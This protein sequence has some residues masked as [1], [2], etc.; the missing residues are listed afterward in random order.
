[1]LTSLLL[2]LVCAVQAENAPPTEEKLKALAKDAMADIERA[3][4]RRF[5]KTPTIKHSKRDEVQAI[6]IK[7]LLPQMGLIVPDLKGE[8][9][10]QFT[11]EQAQL[12]VR[13][14]MAKYEPGADC[15]HI[16]PPP[17][18]LAKETPEQAAGT[19]RVVVTHEL[20]HA[21]DQQTLK[22]FDRI[23]GCKTATDLE[24]LN[25]L[26]EGH[27]Q[28]LARRIFVDR[29]EEKVFDH[30]ESL[31]L[32]GPPDLGEAEKL[33][34]A[35]M[36]QSVKFSYIDGRAFFDGLVKSGKAGYVAD[37]FAKPPAEKNGVLHPERFYAP[38]ATAPV[39]DFEPAFEAFAAPFKD[40]WLRQK[41]ELD[42]SVLRT[43]FADFVDAKSVEAAL[44]GLLT[45][46]TLALTPKATPGAK[47]A[48][49]LLCRHKDAAAADRFRELSMA[50][51]R[52]RDERLKE[53]AIR[54]AKSETK[55]LKTPSG[56]AMTFV[57]KVV[58]AQ[59]QEVGVRSA[60][61]SFGPFHLEIQY[62]N[63]DT[64]EEALLQVVDKIQSA[65]DKAK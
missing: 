64:T 8:G 31:I 48:V 25:A 4:G 54:I 56:R 59:G 55:E 24:I 41:G 23:A 26:L 16:L 11:R 58:Q 17:E 52:A 20:V 63:E 22:V 13:F 29:K 45:S 30:Y 65:M 60:L 47:M 3:S 27:A 38:G 21:L 32:A 43:V 28:H 62:T 35:V 19:L 53:G 46:K 40:D 6:L 33:V 7:E 51:S 2:A 12:Y 15:I 34:N 5:S 1:M 18:I 36:T 39:T 37:A 14:L 57:Y 42:E 61:A 10:T 50:L 9:L 44:K 49:L